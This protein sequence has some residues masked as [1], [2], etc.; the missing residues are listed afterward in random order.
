[1]FYSYDVQRHQTKPIP[2]CICF[3]HF[4]RHSLFLYFFLSHYSSFSP[5]KL[6]S[7]FLYFF[8]SFYTGF[9]PSILLSLLL[10]FSLSP[11]ILLFLLLHLFLFT[12]PGKELGCM[13]NSGFIYLTF[14]LTVNLHNGC[15]SVLF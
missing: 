14:D 11:F 5:F 10:Y 9:S 15:V 13:N 3:S 1:M 7:L 4:I 6:L 2:F 8:I 12:F